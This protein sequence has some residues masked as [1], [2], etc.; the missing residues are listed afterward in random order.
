MKKFNLYWHDGHEW[1]LQSGSPYTEEGIRKPPMLVGD[2]CDPNPIP[3][4]GQTSD[5]PGRGDWRWE[6]VGPK[7]GYH[8]KK[9]KKGELGESSKI[10]EEVLEL[11]DA[12][13]QG[14]KVM[15]LAELADIV[16]AVKF[17]LQRHF[18]DVFLT[19]L[20]K[21]ADVTWRAFE[22]GRRK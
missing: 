4:E 2:R 7:P 16:G 21:M 10:L 20:E 3:D 14:V 17:Y 9:I 11:Q 15:Q 5:K 22:N 12:E 8:L 19:D 1:V 18:K 6:L 13:E